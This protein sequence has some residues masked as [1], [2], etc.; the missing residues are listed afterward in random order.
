MVGIRAL[1]R[2]L[3]LSISTVSRALNN[4]GDVSPE[5]RERVLA[6]AA[7][8][9]Y[10][11]NQSGRSLRKGR[12][13]TVGLMLPAKGEEANYT[14]SLFLSLA[15][16]IQTALAKHDLDLVIYQNSSRDDEFARLKRIVERQ[17]A[18]GIILAGTRKTDVRLDYVADREFPF[19]AFGRSDSGGEHPW[20]DLDFEQGANLAVDRLVAQGHR[21]IAIGLPGD[22]AMQGYVH[23]AGYRQALARHGIEGREL[24]VRVD[25]LTER[26]GYRMT[27]ALLKQPDPPTA[28]LFQ[29]DCMAIGAYRKLSEMGLR[30]GRDIAI[31]GGVLTGEICN[32]LYPRLTGYVVALH[33]LGVCMGEAL[34]ARMP[35]Y[36][37]SYPDTLVHQLWPLALQERNSDTL[38]IG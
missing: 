20:L 3:N 10:S 24:L 1:A 36:A 29:S 34:L 28:I 2:Q 5:T 38:V 19:V 35:N 31:S 32:Y 11:P 14:W 23:L 21:R 7:E 16:G 25:E 13:S 9:G 12:L 30:A 26:G 37:P 6:A 33:E 8:L 18:D 15:E 17:Q 4:G 27:E 22:D